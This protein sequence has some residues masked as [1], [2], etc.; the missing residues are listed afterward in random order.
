METSRSHSHHAPEGLERPSELTL[1]HGEVILDLQAHTVVYGE[2]DI[3][4]N[5]K[6]Y[7][8]LE[9][10]VRYPRHVLSYDAIIDRIWS[11][12]SIPTYSCI[13]T[14]IKR[15]RKAFNAANY[16]GEIVKNVR[17]LGYRLEPLP[18]SEVDAIYPS[19]SALQRFFKARAIEYLVLDNRWVLRYLSPG[20]IHYS[21]Y[22]SECTIGNAIWDG[23]PELVGLESV[24][25]EVIAGSLDKFELQ[26][27][28][29]GQN[30]LRPDYINFHA[31]VDRDSKATNCLFVFFED[32]S[33]RM[34]SRQRL[35]QN[36]N[37]TLLLME[38]L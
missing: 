23:F 26:G 18:K 3:K 34:K 21:D 24:L 16:P 35:V 38:R 15:L 12:E 1:S 6:E 36:F 19:N 9:L 7:A 30:P 13:R 22:P 2:T 8:L 28:G 20:A 10:F 17:G 5:P 4:L 31:I 32:A 29:R 33:D 27:I 37:E 14:H 11:D 25:E